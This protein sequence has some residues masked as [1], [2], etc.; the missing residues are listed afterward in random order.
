MGAES[1]HGA[2]VSDELK[3]QVSREAREKAR[4]MA[5]EALAKRLEEIGM[6]VVESRVYDGVVESIS[7]ELNQLRVVLE[8]AE[9]VSNERQWARNQVRGKAGDASTNAAVTPPPQVYGELDD[10][11][12]VRRAPLPSAHSCV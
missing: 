9:S 5:K 2:Q 11:K 7:N 8:S 4:A 3:N 10:S 1:A 6:T 12:L